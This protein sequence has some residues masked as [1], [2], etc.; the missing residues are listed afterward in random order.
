MQPGEQDEI[1]AIRAE[2]RGLRAQ[3]EASS[4]SGGGPWLTMPYGGAI[5]SAAFAL[6]LHGTDAEFSVVAWRGFEDTGA[7]AVAAIALGH[8]RELN[9]GA[10]I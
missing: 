10:R 6:L 7:E 3:V 9:R 8:E 5:K 2:L 4:A 1:Q